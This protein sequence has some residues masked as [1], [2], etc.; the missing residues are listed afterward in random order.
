MTCRLLSKG[1]IRFSFRVLRRRAS[2]AATARF[3]ASKRITDKDMISRRMG[4]RKERGLTEIRRK[5]RWEEEGRGKLEA[6][7]LLGRGTEVRESKEGLFDFFLQAG[8]FFP[9]FTHG[10]FVSHTSFSF[11]CPRAHSPLIVIIGVF[12]LDFS[13]P[14]PLSQCCCCRVLISAWKVQ[15]LKIKKVR[16]LFFSAPSASGAAR[17]GR[18]D[19]Q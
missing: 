1:G 9:L 7:M 14:P 2:G 10:R 11:L 13:L 4:R 6:T 19:Q 15:N 8:R 12:S 17:Q 16:V 3:F 18:Q 5:G